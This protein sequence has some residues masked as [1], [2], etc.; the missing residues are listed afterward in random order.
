MWE[1]EVIFTDGTRDFI[2]GYNFAN[3][4]VR[5]GKEP[6]DVKKVIHQVYID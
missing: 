2:F 6:K 5:S 1:Y 4:C 3:A